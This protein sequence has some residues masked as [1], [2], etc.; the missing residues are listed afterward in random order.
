[1]A[2]NIH[3]NR[4]SVTLTPAKLAAIKAALDSIETQLDFLIA[5]TPKER[6]SL[7]KVAEGNRPFVEDVASFVN[8][9]SDYFP[10]H[11]PLVEFQKDHTLFAQIDSFS[12]RL[13]KLTRMVQ[14]TQ[15]LAGHEALSAGL[16]YYDG[17]KSAEADGD[18]GASAVVSRLSARFDGQGNFKTVEETDANDTPEA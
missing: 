14:D 15:M 18:P 10:K 12:A 7:P 16:R 17:A 8:A 6:Q 3:V 13:E 4:L 2:N 9:G 11:I 5:L 1:M